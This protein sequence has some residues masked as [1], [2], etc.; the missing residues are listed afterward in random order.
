MLP[1][2]YA[3]LNA[4]S[5]VVNVISGA[6]NAQQQAQFLRDYAI[7]F[8]AVAIVEVESDTAV[9]IGGSYTDGVFTEPPAPPAPEPLPEVLPEPLPEVITETII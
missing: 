9:W 2:R 1:N 5:I 3:F 8:G 4:E 6:L 7:L